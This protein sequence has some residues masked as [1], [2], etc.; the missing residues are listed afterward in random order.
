MESQLKYNMSKVKVRYLR[1]GDGEV[2]GKELWMTEEGV[3]IVMEEDPGLI[4]IIKEDLNIKAVA[5]E[6][7]E[8]AGIDYR[9]EW[10][11]KYNYKTGRLSESLSNG[12]YDWKMKLSKE[13]N[14]KLTMEARALAIKD[15]KI[16]VE[17][18]AKILL[19]EEAALQSSDKK[20]INQINERRAIKIEYQKLI[21]SMDYSQASEILVKYILSHNHIFTTKNDQK[22]EIWIYRNGIYVRNGKS[23]IEEILRKIL[24][25]SYYS[26]YIKQ[27]F[28]KIEADTFIEQ[29][30]LFLTNYIDEV[31]VQNGILNILTK[32]LTDFTPS[33]IFFSKLPVTFRPSAKCPKIDLFLQE[34]LANRDDRLVFYELGGFCLLKEYRFE[35]AAMFIG[36][37]RNGK[38]K[39]LELLKRVIG[40]ENCYS[41][42]LSS[43][44]SDNPN[45]SQL[46]GKFVNLAGDIDNKDL[47]DTGLFK[48]LTGR[49][50]ITTPRKYLS[51]LTF[52][53]YAKFIFACNELPMVYDLSKGFWNRWILLEFPYYFADKG[54]YDNAS[55]E[56]RKG[57]KIKDEDIIS[58]ISSDE[59]LS[60]LLNQFLDGLARLIKNRNFSTTKGTEEIKN[61]WIRKSNSFIAFCMDMIEEEYDVKISK[62][63]L[64]RKYSVYCKQ[65]KVNSK[66]D[67]VIKIT[68]QDMY[69]ASEDRC[70]DS[71]T[72][73]WDWYWVGLK[74]K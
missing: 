68:L 45:V 57:W 18:A 3:K 69:G 50:L 2:A 63:E 8:I 67:K 23:E 34:V 60:G 64:R 55:E 54:E 46:Q 44:S 38:G 52:E 48:S 1:D 37:G 15:G 20:D 17:E 32:E 28:D 51:S 49:D 7:A 10:L 4:E 33:K 30:K 71:Q 16:T 70:L 58:K 35:K 9:K 31:P 53:N 73:T 62:K 59:E 19:E 27:V 13:D 24:E 26:K 6:L 74:W 41:M 61:L 72:D 5:A 21:K 65:H 36:T 47:K 12:C 14:E 43:L 39:S 25:E 56:V 66:G 42:P 29:D 11:S 22:R 40:A